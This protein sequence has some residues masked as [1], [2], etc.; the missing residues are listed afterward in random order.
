MVDVSSTTMT[1]ADGRDEYDCML[2]PLMHQLYGG[3]TASAI[4]I[5]WLVSPER[6]TVLIDE[7]PRP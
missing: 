7:A 2:S 1:R 6:W 4:G 5:G 3:A